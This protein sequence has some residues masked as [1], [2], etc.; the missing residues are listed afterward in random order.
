MRSMQKYPA[1]LLFLLCLA[2]RGGAQGTVIPA[3]IALDPAGRVVLSFSAMGDVSRLDIGA[4][5]LDAS[6]TILRSMR[7]PT[8]VADAALAASGVLVDGRSI[9]LGGSNPA[10]S[11]GPDLVVLRFPHSVP[12]I[13]NEVGES[14]DT[15]P[16]FSLQPAYP[17]PVRGAAPVTIAFTLAQTARVRIAL[18]DETG[19]TLALMRDM[20]SDP[21]A[22]TTQLTLGDIPAGVYF[23]EFRAGATRAVQRVLVLR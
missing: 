21:G 11:S 1:L 4:T 8:T 2:Q 20:P 19:R 13:P 17:N 6:G 5:V 14:S 7:A 18:L 16:V 3:S 22:H 15:D 9:T 12:A 23:V 10:A